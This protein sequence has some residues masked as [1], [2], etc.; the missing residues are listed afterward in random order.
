MLQV[1]V[2]AITKRSLPHPSDPAQLYEVPKTN[3]NQGRLLCHTPKLK[4]LDKAAISEEKEKGSSEKQQ[5]PW[6]LSTVTKVEEMKLILNVVPI[7]LSSLTFGICVAQTSTFFIKQASTMNRRISTSHHHVFMVPPAT[8]YSLS[9]IGMIIA[10]VIYDKILEPVLRKARGKERR[11]EILQRI[12]IGMGFVSVTMITAALVER[13]RLEAVERGI[14]RMS[15][16]W[17][18]PQFMIMGFGDGF[19]LVGLQEYFYDQVPDKMRSLGIALY[20]SVIG[21][22]NFLSSL[23]ITVVDHVITQRHGRSWFGKDLNSSRLDK[24]YWLLAA[25]NGGE[26]MHLY[27]GS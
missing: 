24:F 21:L 6:R 15:V 5:S 7:W 27:V 16:F 10:V 23:L 9:A 20:L 17:L 22:G 2:A 14:S 4:F 8:V 12:G 1:M 13:K 11:I 3:K 26:L 18:T 25:M 19:A